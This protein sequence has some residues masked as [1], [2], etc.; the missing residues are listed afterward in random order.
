M[1]VMLQTFF[2]DCPRIDNKEGQWWNYIREQIPLPGGASK[3][4]M[5]RP[6]SQSTDHDGRAQS[7]A[8]PRGY[9]L[10]AVK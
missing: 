2:W 7:C 3:T 8:P 10:Y 5:T 9:A 4:D 6:V 1:G